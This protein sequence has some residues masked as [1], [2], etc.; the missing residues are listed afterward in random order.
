MYMT[1]ILN[2]LS[3]WNAMSSKENGDWHSK[4]R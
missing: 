2:E 4:R 1:A 3:R